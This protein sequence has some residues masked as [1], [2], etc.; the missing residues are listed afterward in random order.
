MAE[1]K[2]IVETQYRHGDVQYAFTQ[3][4]EINSNKADSTKKSYEI[5][6]SYLIQQIKPDTPCLII[7]KRVAEDFL[8]WLSSLKHLQQNTK[9]G[10]QKNFLKFL[11]FL[12]EYEYIPKM[13]LINRDV[14]SRAKV[15]EPLIFT[16]EDRQTIV[17]G[18]SNNE[19]NGNFRT[20]IMLLMY[21]GLRPSDV[22]NVTT[23]QIDLE[24]MEIKFYSSK[25]D[26]WFIRPIHPSLKEV[27]AARIAEVKTGRLFE[28]SEVKNIGKAFR[29]F[30]RDIKLSAKGYTLRTFRKDFISR[31]QEAGISINTTALLVGH[32]NI[33]TT[34]THYT[35]L[36]TK[37]LK[38][39]LSKL[40]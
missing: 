39:E 22:I 5:F 9:Y 13:F 26:K 20:M 12:F 4:K 18:L 31:S 27:L 17:D 28:Y 38:D 30:M 16:A 34:M 29:R 24:K 36:S 37:H 40:K 33:K 32:S 2:K 25:I 8:L 23:D 10:I 11:R 15:S 3:F 19:K 7:N 6:Y 14:K 1:I 35:K 21:T